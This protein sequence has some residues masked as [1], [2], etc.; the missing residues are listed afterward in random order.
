M[1]DLNDIAIFVKVAQFESF[2]R[3]AHA[4]GMPVSTVSRRVSELEQQLGV[5]LLQRTTRKLTLTA[6]GVDYFHQC[7]EPLNILADAERVLKQTQENPE[8]TLKI[9]VPVVLREQAFM[10]FISAFLK[11]YPR[12]KIDLFISNEFIN[13]VEQ[14]VDVAIRFGDLEDSTL[15][16]KK[17]G[18]GVRY[19]VATP[20]YLEGRAIPAKP[21]DLKAHQCVLLNGKNGEAKWD[22]ASGRKRISVEVAGSVSSRDFNSVSFFTHR[23]H[24]IGLLPL[25]YCEELLKNGKLVRILPQWSSVQIPVHVLYPTRKFLPARLL[26]FLE[27]L[28]S[29]ESPFWSKD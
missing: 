25:N 29:W 9:T 16:A 13:L 24:G 11:S 12:I 15:I 3:A 7:N 28:K 5:T 2:S 4:L 23:G 18:A 14:N 21:D 10:D 19:L 1:A 22:L 17:L 20:E 8:G 26:V 27:A 6:Q